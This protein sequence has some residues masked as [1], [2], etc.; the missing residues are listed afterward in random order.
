MGVLVFAFAALLS[1]AHFFSE[2]FSV[3]V[4][5]SH[6]KI[7]SFSAGVFITY[8]FLGLLPEFAKGKEIIGDN[9]FLF[10]LCG[11]ALFHVL[12]KYLYQHVK[13]KKELLKDVAELHTFGFFFDHFVIGMILFFAL[14][15]ENVFLGS[16]AFLPLFFHTITS[17]ISLQ[18]IHEH[19][20]KNILLNIALSASPL[21][22]VLFV[23]TLNPPT[24]LYY[25]IFSFLIG[26]LLY[27]ATRDSLPSGASGNIKF[28]IGGLLVSTTIIFLA[29]TVK[30]TGLI[31]FSF[32]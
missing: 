24:D 18:H 8:I 30:E 22:G 2:Y 31:V 6:S 28:F 4:E 12:E 9:A 32:A 27:V 1:V 14:N 19:F 10:L 21:I 17:S 3:H 5:K 23:S 15:T 13:N 26:M 11:F 7:L 29:N 20:N 16:M 25:S